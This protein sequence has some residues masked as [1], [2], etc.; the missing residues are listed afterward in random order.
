MF[1]VTVHPYGATNN[2]AFSTSDKP[3]IPLL[4]KLVNIFRALRERRMLYTS[5]IFVH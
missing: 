3:L 4:L 1:T 5:C 2:T